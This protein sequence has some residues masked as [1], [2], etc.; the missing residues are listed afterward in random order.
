[1]RATAVI[2]LIITTAHTTTAAAEPGSFGDR[3][4]IFSLSFTDSAHP[5]P[6]HAEDGPCPMI[7]VE[8]D[9]ACPTSVYPRLISKTTF[10]RG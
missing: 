3:V 4:F 9:A 5:G 8:R 10:P 7:V 1:V 2:A 6:A